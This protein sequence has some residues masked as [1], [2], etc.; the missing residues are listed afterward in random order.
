[1]SVREIPYIFVG[2]LVQAYK[3]VELQLMQLFRS[4]LQ[5]RIVHT[6]AK[7]GIV[8]D[9]DSG[10]ESNNNNSL[11]LVDD[12]YVTKKS[13]Y[14]RIIRIKVH[15][16]VYFTRIANSA[17]MGMGE[18]YMDGNWDCDELTE[19]FKRIMREKVFLEYLNPWNRFL[20]YAHLSFFNLQT[21]SKAW[22]VGKQHYD[23]GS[24]SLP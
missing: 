9:I 7:L 5:R 20:N 8:F 6:Y 1:M 17:S 18:T 23:L 14:K 13:A 21:E 3:W 12:K 24:Q 22:E 19:L 16:K 15:D 2:L 4:K 11:A 10:K